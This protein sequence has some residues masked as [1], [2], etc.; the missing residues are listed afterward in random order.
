MGQGRPSAEGAP[1]LT[2]HLSPLVCEHAPP[3]SVRIGRRAVPGNA[4]TVEGTTR[5][6]GCSAWASFAPSP[7][8]WLCCLSLCPAPCECWAMGPE[9][10]G[11]M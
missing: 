7:P 4:I 5:V 11:E 9:A 10:S 2:E 6:P 1:D 8:L 3:R